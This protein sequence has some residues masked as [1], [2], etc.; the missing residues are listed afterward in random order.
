MRKIAIQE[1]FAN[2]PKAAE[3]FQREI[4][5]K[6][7]ELN[8]IEEI[9]Q[10][11][12]DTLLPAVVLAARVNGCVCDDLKEHFLDTMKL[13]E[14][15]ASG[16]IQRFIEDAVQD[17]NFQ[18]SF[19]NLA[20]S[21]AMRRKCHTTTLHFICYCDEQDG[22]PFGDHEVIL[23]YESHSG[24]PYCGRCTKDLPDWFVEKLRGDI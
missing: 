5:P 2:A 18:K 9:K 14:E 8:S 10:F 13:R 21:Y 16:N 22:C 15:T 7:E 11:Y 23:R 3:I 1:F 12:I 24:I 17:E 6:A 4:Y 20:R 19:L